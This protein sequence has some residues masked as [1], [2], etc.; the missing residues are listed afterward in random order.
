M[1]N[2]C[3]TFSLWPPRITAT[4]RLCS[5][6]N[7]FCGSMS[8]RETTSSEEWNSWVHRIKGKKQLC[9]IDFCLEQV[10]ASTEGSKLCYSLHVESNAALSVSLHLQARNKDTGALAAAKQIET[11]CEDELEDYIVE[12]DI[13]AK[14]DHRYIVKLLDA[15]YFDNKLWVGSTDIC[16]RKPQM[17]R[18]F[19][20]CF[21]FLHTYRLKQN[22]ERR[23]KAHKVLLKWSDSTVMAAWEHCGQSCL[24]Y[25]KDLICCLYLPSSQNVLFS[26]CWRVSVSIHWVFFATSPHRATTH[27]SELSAGKEENRP[28]YNH[29]CWQAHGMR[30]FHCN[31]IPYRVYF[32][33]VRKLCWKIKI[34]EVD[35]RNVGGHRTPG[36]HNAAE[37][38]QNKDQ[39]QLSVFCSPVIFPPHARSLGQV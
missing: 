29:V 21:M 27:K 4:P 22:K 38:V 33:T 23:H 11:K 5:A 16:L 7:G 3:D 19:S 37:T 26:L 25:Q 9:F 24:V 34:R 39:F 1:C 12:I 8:D 30:L 14:C 31:R 36:W 13:L 10:S 2:Q 28:F 6:V 20:L 15:F 32:S 35:C 18:L 17:C